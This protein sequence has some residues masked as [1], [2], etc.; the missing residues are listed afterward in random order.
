MKKVFF[1]VGDCANV[2]DNATGEPA[3]IALAT[4]AVRSGIVAGL[5]AVGKGAETVVV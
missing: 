5:N 3:Y 1:A 2:Y 4:N